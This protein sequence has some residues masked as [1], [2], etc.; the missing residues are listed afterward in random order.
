MD[1]ER[2]W[3]RKSYRCAIPVNICR[4]ARLSGPRYSLSITQDPLHHIANDAEWNVRRDLH[5]PDG[6][7]QNEMNGSIA[8]LL[9]MMEGRQ[10][11]LAVHAVQRRQSADRTDRRLDACAIR[12]GAFL[13]V[14]SDTR[15][16]DHSITHG[17]AVFDPLISRRRLAGVSDGMA[18]IEDAPQVA[19]FFV[20]HHHVRLDG[21]A[22]CDKTLDG[23]RIAIAEQ[24]C[25]SFEILE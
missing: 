16:R 25:I 11:R 23:C 2:K 17:F 22:R 13:K 15:S 20:G 3:L 12:L 1:A 9:I 21:G 24:R 7:R 18:E 14:Q 6:A 4:T 5:T 10:N 19:L 8:D